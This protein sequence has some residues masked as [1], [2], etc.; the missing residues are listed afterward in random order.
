MTTTHAD[1]LNQLLANCC[2]LLSADA[3]KQNDGFQQ[4]ILHANRSDF[5]VEA[6]LLN[7]RMPFQYEVRSLKKV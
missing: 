7:D 4:Y 1:I 3:V 5:L 6:K 2:S